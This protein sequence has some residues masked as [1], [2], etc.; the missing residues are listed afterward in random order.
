MRR[1]A[2]LRHAKSS[3][4]PGVLD[5][6]RPLAPR[7][8]VDAEAA[9][10]W[11]REHVGSLDQVVVSSALR[12]RR[13]W[14]LAAGGVG[15]DGAADND[16]GASSPVTIDPRIYEASAATLLEVLRELPDPVTT[17]LL[18]GHNPGCEDLVDLLAREREPAAAAVLARKYPTAGIAVVDIDTTWGSL[19]VR[20]AR[21]VEFAVPRG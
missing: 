19:A 3:Y 5:H 9:G 6:D 16:L 1:L 14:A 4:P 15:S 7:G 13:T 17:A 21:L 10:A 2:V 20:T 8:V 12:A 18:V 11:L